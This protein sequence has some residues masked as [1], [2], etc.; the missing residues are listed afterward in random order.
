V[1]RTRLGPSAVWLA[2]AALFATA[3]L[4]AGASLATGQPDAGRPDAHSQDTSTSSAIAAP[5]V[6]FRA[7]YDAR[8]GVA[9]GR[10]DMALLPEAG[11]ADRFAYRSVTRPRG[12]A[13]LIRS[14]PL[15]ECTVF[16]VNDDGSWLASAH[17]YIDGEPGKG[18]SSS[19]TFDWSSG[20]ARARYKERDVELPVTDT[21]Y[22][23][24]LEQLIVSRD[25]AAGRDPGPYRIV[26]RAELHTIHYERVGEARVETE[27]GA[28]D[29]EIYRR[30]REGSRRSSVTWFAPALDWLPVRIEQY[31]GDDRQ[32]TVVLS[33]LERP[34]DGTLVVRQARGSVTPLCP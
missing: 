29:T 23:R 32:A 34:A 30:Q 26:Q 27:A 22:D 20:V 14:A 6:P 7:T 33:E 18:K 12:M 10:V 16:S 1:I 9:R 8:I 5:P 21:I 19:A 25:L 3:A 13:R 28:F 11:A 4:T 24:M 17:Q 2:A 15:I 31:K